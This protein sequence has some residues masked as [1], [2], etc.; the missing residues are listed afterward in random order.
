VLRAVLLA[1]VVL[2]TGCSPTPITPPPGNPA[3][4]ATSTRPRDID[5]S[6]LLPCD[7][8][9]PTQRVELGLDGE[10]RLSS[11]N[12]ALFGNARSC[13]IS[14]FDLQPAVRMSIT[15]GVEYGIERFTDPRLAADVET[16][17]I[18]GYP[19]VLSP[20]PPSTPDNCLIA[21]DTASG[22]MVGVLLAD[23]G[24]T[25]PIP[26]DQLCRDVPRFAEA[27]MSTLL[28]R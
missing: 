24:N 28:A 9:T 17:E 15:L 18:A 8:L 22:Q 21:V 12:D 23:G 11:G 5:I 19:A 25:P 1:L 26:L 13:N 2:L 4:P 3:D 6:G 7:L 16:I 14:R 10:P 27:V 20:P